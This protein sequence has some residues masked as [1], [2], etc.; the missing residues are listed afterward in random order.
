MKLQLQIFL[1]NKYKYPNT[2]FCTKYQNIKGY[3]IFNVAFVLPG[4]AGIM[5]EAQINK[6]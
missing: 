6:K 3:K 2:I 1:N 5:F 4:L